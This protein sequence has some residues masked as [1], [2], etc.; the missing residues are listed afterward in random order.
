MVRERDVMNG[1]AGRR[2]GGRSEGGWKREE[3]KAGRKEEGGSPKY[4]F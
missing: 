1:D 4:V 2:G 3:G